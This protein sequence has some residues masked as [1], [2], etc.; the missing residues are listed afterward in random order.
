MKCRC[1]SWPRPIEHVG[2]PTRH[3]DEI[4]GHQPVAA[5]DE[6]EH[7][8]GLADAALAGEQESDAE[9]VGE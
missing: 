5:L 2:S 3:H 6:I 8:F 9:Y 7:T 4:V 1:S